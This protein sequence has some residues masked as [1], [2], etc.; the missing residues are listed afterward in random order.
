[1]FFK[2]IY[3]DSIMKDSQRRAMMAKKHLTVSQADKIG[4]Y[5]VIVKT[6]NGYQVLASSHAE[7][8]EFSN[9]KHA[10][11]FLKGEFDVMEKHDKLFGLEGSRSKDWD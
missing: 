5:P 10:R 4:K 7:S 3:H 9:L 6:K 2:D 1:M 8:D 11:E